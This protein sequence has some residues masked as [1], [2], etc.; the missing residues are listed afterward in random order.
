MGRS[1]IQKAL[2]PDPEDLWHVTDMKRT[3]IQRAL[4]PD[5][6]E[7]GH[8]TDPDIATW[9]IFDLRV[10]KKRDT[11][12]IFKYSAY[13]KDSRGIF[14]EAMCR[15]N[16]IPELLQTYSPLMDNEE[17]ILL[18]CLRLIAIYANYEDTFNLYSLLIE[19]NI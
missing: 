6:D 18:K 8:V 15:N 5:P 2:S 13:R 19:L 11:E 12:S 1:L 9:D 16:S 4:S 7:L 3:L 14:N 10:I 17:K